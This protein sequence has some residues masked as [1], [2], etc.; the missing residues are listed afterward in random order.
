MFRNVTRALAGAPALVLGHR[1]GNRAL[2][3]ARS[4]QPAP[5]PPV[6]AWPEQRRVRMA[7][8][9]LLPDG[10]MCGLFAVDIVRFNAPHRD[11]DIRVYVHR[12][13][14][15][16]LET[17]FDRS[18]VP[19]RECAHEDCGDG[20]FVVIP[21]AIPVSGLL[22]R[23]P[24]CLLTQVQRH[25]RVSCEDARIQLRLAVHVGP[26]HHDG[27]GF[28]GYPVNLLHRMIDAPALR[29]LQGESG[30]E[31]ALITSCYLYENV[32]T[33]YPFMPL[34]VRVKETRTRAWARTLGPLAVPAPRAPSD[35]RLAV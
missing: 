34:T 10:Q 20:V 15:D 28:V 30:A 1:A 35:T 6:S 33:R 22:N 25:N 13:L 8:P 24:D 17:A 16:M 32:C 31:L 12:S 7:V 19:W 18:G 4:P 29:R 11:D 27:H 3:P 2:P 5:A 9:P 23:V 14:Y 21:P 26:V